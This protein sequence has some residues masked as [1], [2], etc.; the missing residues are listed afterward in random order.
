M[1]IDGQMS[2][3]KKKKWV[4]MIDFGISAIVKVFKSI[5]DKNNLEEK[6]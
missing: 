3:T 5:M 4:N 1:V 6:R 2:K